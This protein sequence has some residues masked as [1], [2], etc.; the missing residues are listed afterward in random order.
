MNNY[1]TI[2]QQYDLKSTPARIAVL[3][4]LDERRQPLDAD[5]IYDHLRSEHD[6]ADKVT[7][8]RTLDTFYQKGLINRLDF[9]EGKYRYELSDDDHHHLICE[10]CGRVEDIPDCNVVSLLHKL[11]KET[12]FLVKHH[13]L[14]FF[15]VCQLCQH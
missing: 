8:Y 10:V 5:T 14:E 13:S 2:L 9:R 11:N 6:Q 15:G 1:R 3:S 7:I 4:F 12:G